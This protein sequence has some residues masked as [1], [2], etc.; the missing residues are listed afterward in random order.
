MP[1]WSCKI[2]GLSQS[3]ANSMW[4]KL[5]LIQFTAPSLLQLMA[6]TTLQLTSISSTTNHKRPARKRIFM[7]LCLYAS[8]ETVRTMRKYNKITFVL[9]YDQSV[10]RFCVCSV[11]AICV[12]IRLLTSPS[13]QCTTEYNWAH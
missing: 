1:R 4:E 12:L 2:T 9:L 7:S 6:S 11:Y 10:Y 3:Q 5:P 8:I 13:Q